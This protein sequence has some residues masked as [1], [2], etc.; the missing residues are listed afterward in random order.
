MPAQGPVLEILIL[1]PQ[2]SWNLFALLSVTSTWPSFGGNW[3]LPPS[4]F[5]SPHI[6]CWLTLTECLKYFVRLS[7]KYV[8]QSS[9]EPYETGL[10]LQ[11]GIFYKWRHRQ[12]KVQSLAQDYTA[13]LWTQAPWLQALCSW[14][15]TLSPQ[16][17]SQTLIHSTNMCGA[18]T[19]Q[20][21]THAFI[22]T[23]GWLHRWQTCV[24]LSEI[25]DLKSV[26]KSLF[27]VEVLWHPLFRI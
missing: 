17:G 9:P 14:L 4:S 3:S 16:R 25:N 27:L 2:T 23:W 22:V 10:L 21:L 19:C 5:L 20:A 18:P 24:L 7:A 13:E 15:L 6:T 8:L 26:S 12:R 1:R 11:S